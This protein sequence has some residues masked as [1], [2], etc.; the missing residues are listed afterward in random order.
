MNRNITSNDIKAT[1]GQ[2][3]LAYAVNESFS[4]QNN[5]LFYAFVNPA[6]YQYFY[7]VVKENL[8]WYD[9][10]VEGFHNVQNGIFSSR[11]ASA[12][13]SGIA[14]TIFG[15]GIRF[16]NIDKNNKNYDSINFL[17]N[18]WLE[19]SEFNS[20]LRDAIEYSC[21]GGTS[22][23]KINQSYNK[24]W[25][26]A[27]RIDQFYYRTNG[28]GELRDVTSQL[29]VY[30]STSNDMTGERTCF[31]LCEHRFYK[32][33]K[34]AT[35][36]TLLN[37]KTRYFS[38]SVLK[39]FVEYTVNLFK[40]KI[41]QSANHMRTQEHLSW[42]DIPKSIRNDIKNDYTAIRINEP[43]LLPFT[44][45]G[46]ELLMVAGKDKHIPLGYYGKSFLTDIRTDLVEFDII[47]SYSMRD[48][49]NGQGQVGVP[50]ALSIGQENNTDN[51]IYSGSKLNYETFSGN[52]D[53]Q[54]PIITQFELRVKEWH[55]ATDNCLKKMA[56]KIGMSPKV[57]ASYLVDFNQSSGEAKTAT[58]IQSDDDSAY[59]FSDRTRKAIEPVIDKL[60]HEILKFYVLDTNVHCEFISNKTENRMSLFQEVFG[61]YQAG[62]IDLRTALTRLNPDY[63]EQELDALE[64]R[65]DKRMQEL[66]KKELMDIGVSGEYLD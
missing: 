34:K 8:D 44:N 1:T 57:I 58:E 15:K 6:Y 20:T 16:K 48:K 3:Y 4:F 55:D 7:R 35:P 17:S 52:P 56:T 26:E 31:I 42:L 10:Y 47:H 14:N 66:H 60:I 27:L 65:C 38:K 59:M 24:L 50:K 9:G 43:M 19:E 41:E 23:I 49:F 18:K 5:S 51:N 25:T 2:N 30:C 21:A 54:K 62:F 28:R 53:T 13:M 39:P 12:L 64:T 61:E 36:V 45:L 46:C 11:I 32:E 37:G 40:G 22:L 63:S 33:V 29:K